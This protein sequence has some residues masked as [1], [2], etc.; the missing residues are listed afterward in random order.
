MAYANMVF[1]GYE[2][3]HVTDTELIASICFDGSLIITIEQELESM[4]LIILD[5]DTAIAFRNHLTSLIK[6]MPDNE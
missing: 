5:K 1:Y 4:Q 2:N 3:N 6:K